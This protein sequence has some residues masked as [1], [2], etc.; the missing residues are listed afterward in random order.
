[1]LAESLN[2]NLNVKTEFR[3]IS[4][5]VANVGG[6]HRNTSKLLANVEVL[7]PMFVFIIEPYV[8]WNPPV[9]YHAIELGSMYHNTIW[10]RND[11]V[12]TRLI[13]RIPFGLKIDNIA[14]R[15]V[16]P[17]TPKSDKLILE[18]IEVGDFNLL[19]NK[20]LKIEQ[21][22]QTEL[23]KGKPG[24]MMISS[25]LD[26]RTQWLA[27]DADHDILYAVVK[28]E[29]KAKK[30]I[31]HHKLLAA[32]EDGLNGVTNRD[33][34]TI[35]RKWKKDRRLIMKENTKLINPK[36]SGLSL[37]PWEELYKHKE[38]KFIPNWY[39]PQV[40]YGKL[41]R[42]QSRAEDVNN[43]QS[44]KMIELVDKLDVV[45]RNKLMKAFGWLKFAS[46]VVCL[47]K[48][49]KTPDK[50]TNLRPIQITPW[51]MKIG[52]KSRCE[53]K[54]WLD[55]NTDERCVAFRKKAKIDDIVAWIK[56]RIKD[57]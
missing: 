29:L 46:K 39:V 3:S 41:D 52:E 16:P 53:L 56:S 17:N 2:L 51:N 50:V 4:V 7:L 11:V 18:E 13:S 42:I 8:H 25:K 15:Y 43:F 19:S 34:Y 28:S 21:P 36:I 20:W 48:K 31:D 26:M 49:D 44:K 57:K 54:R 23:R 33:V 45:R 30:K 47:R 10:I 5:V 55:E 9:N 12:K 6:C 27:G 37:E 40:S 35:D 32:L 38:T 22:V 24:G 1:M 14:F